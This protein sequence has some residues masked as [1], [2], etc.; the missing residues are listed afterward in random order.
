[1]NSVNHLINGQHF[2]ILCE[3]TATE[4][5][6]SQ[7][8]FV[9]NIQSIEGFTSYTEEFLQKL[10]NVIQS[11]ENVGIYG[12]GA[13][14]VG[15]ASFLG[16]D[17]QQV[18]CFLDLNQMKANKYSPKTHIPIMLPEKESIQDLDSI[19]IIAPL[20][21]KEI[22]AKLLMSKSKPHSS[23][24]TPMVQASA[25]CQRKSHCEPFARKS[26]GATLHW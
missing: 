3:K 16:V 12:A 15:V 14:G 18:R 25:T 17:S 11:Y 2:S 21:Q 7:E 4:V 5:E 26:K 1:M 22:G 13:H 23:P 9:D 24:S 19:V 10:R 8:E 6:Y 20:H